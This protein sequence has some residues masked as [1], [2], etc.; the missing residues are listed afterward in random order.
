MKSSLLVFCLC[1]VVS[2]A[3][4]KNS[5]N[6]ITDIYV[7]EKEAAF[8]DIS[9]KNERSNKTKLYKIKSTQHKMLFGVLP[10][11]ASWKVVDNRKDNILFE[12]PDNLKVYGDLFAGFSYSKDPQLN[13]FNQQQGTKVKPPKSLEQVIN[14]DLKPYLAK[15]GW[16][17]I[18]LFEI[19]QLAQKD[20]QFDKSLFKSVPEN[21]TYH[22]VGTEWKNNEGKKSLGI[23]RYY[24]NYYTTMP[25]MDWGYTVNALEVSKT[26]Y[27]K[28]KR[29][30][31]NALLNLEINPNWLQKNN[32]FYANQS[33]Q[34]NAQH[35]RRM[36][37]IRAQ[38]QAAINTGNTYSS[39]IDSN[40][41]SWKRRNGMVDAGHSNTIN[42]GIWERNTMHD[43]NGNQYQ[44]EGHYDNVWKGNDD[45]TYLGTNNTNWNPN[46]DNS[47]N[48]IDWELLENSDDNY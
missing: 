37:A 36:A 3:R 9:S 12:G 45:N 23:I 13:Y 29:D 26:G 16:T 18:G 43:Q 33:R 34:S 48:S 24:T 42:T 25:S 11:P 17:Y 5:D 28:A 46:I 35:Q 4:Q 39:I 14:E 40:H 44:V 31:I 2:C 38:G 47:T 32:Q 1:L 19:K 22:C 15:E 6:D 10:I 21:K 20:S 8:D 41:E 27:E 7:S 30:Y